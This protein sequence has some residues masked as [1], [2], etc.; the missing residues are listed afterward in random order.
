LDALDHFVQRASQ[1]YP[2]SRWHRFEV[3]RTTDGYRLGENGRAP[4]VRRDARSTAEALFYR[5]QD[6]SLD[7]LPEFTKIH[8]GCADWRGQRLV[9]VGPGETGKT[10]LMTRLLYDGFAVHCDDIVLLRDGDVLPYPRRFR[11]RRQAL[12]LLPQLATFAAR[13]SDG[14][15]HLLLDP[16][17]LGFEWRIDSRPANAV[18]FRE[19]I[20]GGMARLEECPKYSMAERIMSQSTLPGA[21]AGEWVKHIS[22]LVEQ[23]ACYVVS[24]GNLE[25]SVTVV[26]DGL[27]RSGTGHAQ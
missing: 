3:E 22:K 9:A 7:A 11:I 10:T 13:M 27:S 18:F 21:G 2:V 19:P 24:V 6:L 20:H 15:E 5:M 4:D 8:A 16:L 17:Q 14:E 25:T 12:P 26:K 1:Q 23:A